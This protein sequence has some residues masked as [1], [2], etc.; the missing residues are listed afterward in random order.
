MQTDLQVISVKESRIDCHPSYSDLVLYTKY[1]WKNTKTGEVTW[2]KV[3][4]KPI[5]RHGIK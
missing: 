4:I 3:E 1:G 5:E 2:E